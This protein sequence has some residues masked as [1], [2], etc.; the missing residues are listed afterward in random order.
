MLV[1]EMHLLFHVTSTWRHAKAWGNQNTT[2]VATSMFLGTFAWSTRIAAASVHFLFS[3]LLKTRQ[4][5]HHANRPSLFLQR[6]SRLPHKHANRSRDTT[7]RG[8]PRIWSSFLP[9][10]VRRDVSVGRRREPTYPRPWRF[11]RITRSPSR[12][13]FGWRRVHDQGLRRPCSITNLVKVAC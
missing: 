11:P 12:Q 2:A 6:F 7:D 4:S 1:M 5:D 3:Y 10:I 9:G 13:C 8:F